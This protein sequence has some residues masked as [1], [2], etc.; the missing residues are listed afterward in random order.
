[1]LPFGSGLFHS[2]RLQRKDIIYIY[3]YMYTYTIS[4]Y[5]ILSNHID[6]YIYKPKKKYNI[7]IHDI[8]NGVPCWSTHHASICIGCFKHSRLAINTAPK[9]LVAPTYHK[10][11]WATSS[12]SQL[13]ILCFLA[14]WTSKHGTHAPGIHQRL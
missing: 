10:R 1:M 3:T 9:K 6:I 14:K 8:P 4:T 13:L 7:H 12:H 5:V 2:I 11:S